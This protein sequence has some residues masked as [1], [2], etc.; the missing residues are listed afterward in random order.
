MLTVE[1]E[2]IVGV[3]VIIDKLFFVN[4]LE[5]IIIDFVLVV[6]TFKLDF[7]V[8][9]IIKGFNVVVVLILF[10]VRKEKLVV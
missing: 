9:E 6:L 5:L 8:V 7:I 4:L 10:V 1:V 3:L 2:N